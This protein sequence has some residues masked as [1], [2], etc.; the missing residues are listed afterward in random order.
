MRRFDRF[1]EPPP[2]LKKRLGDPRNRSAWAARDRRSRNAR[3]ASAALLLPACSAAEAGGSAGANGRPGS[4]AIKVRWHGEK[5]AG[6]CKQL[7]HPRPAAHSC[8][9]EPTWL[10]RNG[11]VDTNLKALASG[12]R[13]QWR[14]RPI[15]AVDF[16]THERF[17]ANSRIVA[18][19]LCNQGKSRRSIRAK[20]HM[21]SYPVPRPVRDA[22]AQEPQIPRSRPAARP[23]ARG[24]KPRPGSR[25]RGRPGGR[26]SGGRDRRSPDPH[27]VSAPGGR[28]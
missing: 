19:E 23:P 6:A 13:E 24:R 17:G 11:T 8:S 15:L 7:L 5:A 2:A 21:G 4:T 10:H 16:V 25:R 1:S 3:R 12:V 26:W 22:L 27:P 14:I 18:P 28:S 20:P 9:D